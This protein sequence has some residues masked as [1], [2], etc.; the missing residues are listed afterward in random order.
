[1]GWEA[2]NVH[3]TL[4]PFAPTSSSQDHRNVAE[5]E[6]EKEKTKTVSADWSG[7]CGW[8]DCDR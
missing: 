2:Q 7:N 1:M 4:F 3:V 5:K 6:R 8:R